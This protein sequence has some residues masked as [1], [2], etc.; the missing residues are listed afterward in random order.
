MSLSV[1]QIDGNESDGPSGQ[2]QIDG[3]DSDGPRE[4]RQIDG[5]ERD[6]PR[7]RRQI[8]GNESDGPRGRRQVDGNES[9]GPRGWK[10]RLSISHRTQIITWIGLGNFFLQQ[11]A[12]DHYQQAVAL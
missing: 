3:N 11:A 12:N 6:G 9:N 1:L 7:R 10:F 5:N 4:Q 2:R 8:D